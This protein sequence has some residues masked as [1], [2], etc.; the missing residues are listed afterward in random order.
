MTTPTLIPISYMA[1][2]DLK[3]AEFRGW[4][5]AALERQNRYVTIQL[6]GGPAGKWFV[7][8]GTA[9]ALTNKTKSTPITFVYGLY[10]ATPCDTA[11]EALALFT[12]YLEQ[13]INPYAWINA[14]DGR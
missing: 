10:N 4:D 3:L 1:G 8:D 9:C 2:Y 11:E 6:L 14:K 5:E 12:E 13:P 7:L